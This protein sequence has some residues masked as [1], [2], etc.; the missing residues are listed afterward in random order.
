MRKTQRKNNAKCS[1]C[2]LAGMAGYCIE[3]LKKNSK[4][5]C[6][7]ESCTGGLIA[8]S[9]ISVSGASEVFKGSC[10]AYQI[11]VKIGLLGVDEKIISEYGVVSAQT[12]TA[13]AK[14]AIEEFG[15]DFALSS[16]GY[17]DKS[18]RA[19]IPDGTIYIALASAGGFELTKRLSLSG[20]R[21]S[22]RRAAARAAVKT[23]FEYLKKS[24]DGGTVH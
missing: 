2:S 6:A 7:A 5:L 10:I 8:D 17:A 14:R 11:P 22:N 21:N 24:L 23:L 19:D 16:T 12:A 1:S 3:I 20:S 4:T 15:A 18:D 9:F 13:M